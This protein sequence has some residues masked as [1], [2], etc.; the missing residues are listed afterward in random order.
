MI[1]RDDM[2]CISPDEKIKMK[3][4][5]NN[6]TKRFR[7]SMSP[8]EKV[9]MREK[10]TIGRKRNRLA[11]NDLPTIISPQTDFKC[12]EKAKNIYTGLK[13]LKMLTNINPLYV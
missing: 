3:E 9:K 11:K 7:D 12:M 2:S 10:E 5:A 8:D 4:K 13:I 1:L 6:T